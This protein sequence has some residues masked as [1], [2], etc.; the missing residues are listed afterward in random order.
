MIALIS[1]EEGCEKVY[2]VVAHS[3]MSSVN[4][5]EVAKFLIDR[6][7][8]SKESTI[9][10]IQTLISEVIPFDEGHAYSSAELITKTKTIGL[11]LG[12]RACVALGLETGYPI[13]TADRVWL[14]LDLNCKINLIR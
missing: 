5:S 8:L 14:K 1:Q 11:S 6:H 3:I 13:Y 12:D 4:V 9:N 7:K 10:S 2:S